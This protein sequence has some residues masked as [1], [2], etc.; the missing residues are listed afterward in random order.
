MSHG[1]RAVLEG[2]LAAL[3]PQ[4]AIEIGTAE[5]GSLARVAAHSAE[6]HS[7]DL[8]EP[9][10]DLSDMPH[11]RLHT[12]DSHAL[13]PELLADLGAAGRNVD[14]VLVDG[15]HSAEGVRRDMVDL[16]GSPAIGRTVILM[17]DT[18]NPTVR[19]G[20]QR[21]EYASYPGV[22]RVDLDFFPGFVF[23]SAPL[24]DGE[25]CWGGLGMV[26]VDQGNAPDSGPEQAPFAWHSPFE[27]NQRAL[28]LIDGG[29]GRRPTSDVLARLE[30]AE[31]ARDRNWQ[32]IETMERSL[33]WR[34]TAPLRALS[35]RLRGRRRAA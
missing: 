18:M 6:V 26:L 13:L 20:L 5:G 4:L 29:D 8:V 15:D 9:Q 10:I 3:N 14:F 17:H 25:R 30:A 31:T 35:G 7:F 16:L 1:E 24:E 33:S 34:V 28:E 11:V 22:V 32:A 12:G 27:L 21:V 19:D 23:R 2:V